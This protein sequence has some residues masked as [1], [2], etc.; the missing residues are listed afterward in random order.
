MTRLPASAI[1]VAATRPERPAP[2]TITS[3]S[4]AIASPPYPKMIEAPG[5]IDGQR[6]TPLKF[7]QCEPEA[8]SLFQLNELAPQ[9]QPAGNTSFEF[10]L[11]GILYLDKASISQHAA[12]LLH[13]SRS[14]SGSTG[15]T[16]A[17]A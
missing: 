5:V 6:Q 3:A 14:D 2:T 11:I 17:G 7:S 9:V 12:G 16:G 4:S 8:L 10:D 1:S 13:H 15:W